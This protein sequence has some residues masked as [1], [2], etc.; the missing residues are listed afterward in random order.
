MPGQASC[1]G[2]RQTPTIA[3]VERRRIPDVVS[4]RP[5]ASLAIVAFGLCVLSG[6]VLGFA[7]R[8]HGL[9]WLRTMHSASA[10]VGIISVIA[11]RVIG[12]DGRLRRSTWSIVMTV[13]VVLLVG[14]ALAT[15][16]G[17]AWTSGDASARGMFEI[18]RAHV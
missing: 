4:E 17:L 14:A 16:P 10:A 8:P 2:T 12:S 1:P 13:V 3:S 6:V 5:V 9:G 7:Y 15:G 18:G 11:A